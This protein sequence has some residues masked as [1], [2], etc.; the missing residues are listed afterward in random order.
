MSCI[1][2]P[3]LM[4]F[5]LHIAVTRPVG[6]T[7]QDRLSSE[8]QQVILEEMKAEGIPGAAIGI[9]RDGKVLFSKGFGVASVETG[10]P[11]TADTL[12]RLGS[13]TKMFTA[14]A[15]VQMSL[16]NKIILR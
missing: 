9:V 2:I 15:L 13:T 3:Q 8:L 10:V 14:A 4:I 11:V 7:P 1:V 6:Q 5:M 12:F 16:E